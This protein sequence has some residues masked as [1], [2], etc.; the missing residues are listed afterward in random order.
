MFRT[1]ILAAALISVIS[2]ADQ[3]ESATTPA[4]GLI[5]HLEALVEEGERMVGHQDDYMYGHSWKLADDAS[6][7]VLSDTYHGN[8]R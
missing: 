4:E 7:Y 8:H 6:E 1:G 3:Q 2:C 5:D